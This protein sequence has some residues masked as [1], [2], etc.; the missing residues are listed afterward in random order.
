MKYRLA[1]V[2]DNAA[3]LFLLEHAL[4][5]L[6]L[7]FQIDSFSDGEKARAYLQ[8]EEGER[9]DLFL[10]DLNLPRIGGLELLRVLSLA[11]RFTGVPVM[12]WSSGQ[13][14]EER[15]AVAQFPAVQFIAKPMDL[16]GFI[17][18][19]KMIH[20]TLQVPKVDGP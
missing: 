5:K 18:I 3:D 8:T 20:E 10:F 15:A 19:G 1:V 17:E 11:Q 4:T 6:E 12:V 14:P 13:S 9:P 2:E 7:N 16:G